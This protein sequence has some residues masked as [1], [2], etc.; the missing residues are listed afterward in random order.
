MAATQQKIEA[1]KRRQDHKF[2]NN[3]RSHAGQPASRPAIRCIHL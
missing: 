2:F 1:I 3:F